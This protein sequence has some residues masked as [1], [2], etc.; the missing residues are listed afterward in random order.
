MH[1]RDH[2]YFWRSTIKHSRERRSTAQHSSFHAPVLDNFR[3]LFFTDQRND[4]QRNASGTTSRSRMASLLE[5]LNI[6]TSFLWCTINK[7]TTFRFLY[8]CQA[9]KWRE[10]SEL[11]WNQELL[12]SIFTAE[13]FRKLRPHF[14]NS[15]FS[16]RLWLST[17]DRARNH[18]VRV[19]CKAPCE[20]TQHCWPSTPQ[21]CWMLHVASVCT[22]CCVLVRVVACCWELLCKVWNRSNF[23]VNN[24]Q[25][26]F[27]SVVVEA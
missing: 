18:S 25:H 13:L 27:C 17:T 19:N 5:V 24:S 10:C 12:A 4:V 21:H 14:L 23:W 1:V 3:F 22:P 26:F 11:K 2:S 8:S 16:H 9:T 15:L 7:W 6:L 20:P